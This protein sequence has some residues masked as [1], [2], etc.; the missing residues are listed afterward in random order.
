MAEGIQLVFSLAGVVLVIFLAYYVTYFIS[1]KAQ[2]M[3]KNRPQAGGQK[4][5]LLSRFS[6]AR[7]KS[8]CIV[9]I[10]GSVYIVGI[11]NNSMTLLDKIDSAAFAEHAAESGEV[12]IWP[13]TGNSPFAEFLKLAK[14]KTQQAKDK[15]SPRRAKH[16]KDAGEDE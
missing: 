1:A 2:G 11:T 7:D 14:E 9:E 8:F 5:K 6:I 10:A 3:N 16:E 15:F 13:G 4:I 12:S